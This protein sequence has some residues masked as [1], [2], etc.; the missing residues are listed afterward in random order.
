M[1]R[2]I[3]NGSIQGRNMSLRERK[4]HE[5]YFYHNGRLG[6]TFTESV[7]SD[8]K[9]MEAI[10]K[11]LLKEGYRL[12]GQPTFESSYENGS[13]LKYTFEKE[14]KPNH[15]RNPVSTSPE[16]EVTQPTCET[17]LT[18]NDN[19]QVL[20][21]SVEEIDFSVRSYNC[22]KNLGVQTVRDIVGKTEKD[23][24]EARHFGRRSLL[25]IKETL[26]KMGL[27]LKK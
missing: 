4:T 22:L 21:M 23:L 5:V 14:I 11:K 1:T 16:N 2:L 19:S 15:Y 17:F 6:H 20:N 24:L 7:I 18:V 9:E 25:E 26:A 3:F 12:I 10:F 27:S 13:V 8:L